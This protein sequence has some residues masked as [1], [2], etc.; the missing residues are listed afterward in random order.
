MPSHLHAPQASEVVLVKDN[1]PTCK[2]ARFF[3]RSFT[4]WYGTYFTCLKCGERWLDGEM[5]KRPFAPRWRAE[6]VRMAKRHWRKHA[7]GKS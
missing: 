5:M 3:V 2:K 6:N 7:K 4:D 1:C